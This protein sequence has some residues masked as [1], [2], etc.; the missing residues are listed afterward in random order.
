MVTFCKLLSV[1]F[2][3]TVRW[4]TLDRRRSQIWIENHKQKFM[5]HKAVT[6]NITWRLYMTL[7]GNISICMCTTALASWYIKSFEIIISCFKKIFICLVSQHYRKSKRHQMQRRMKRLSN[8]CVS[9]NHQQF[10]VICEVRTII[11]CKKL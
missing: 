4:I 2:Y 3:I 9:F 6:C 10:I 1:C 8:W 5:I 11:D 7:S